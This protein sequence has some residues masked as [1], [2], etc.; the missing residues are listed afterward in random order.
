MAGEAVDE[1]E[2]Q[3]QNDVDR[4]EFENLHRETIE[5]PVENEEQRQPDNGCAEGQNGI[6]AD[7]LLFG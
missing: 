5:H 4:A 1:V 2:R 7:R 3:S 6:P